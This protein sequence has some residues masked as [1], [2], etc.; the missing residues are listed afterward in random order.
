MK[1][2]LFV[3]IT[4]LLI[5]NLPLCDK[6]NETHN[7]RNSLDWVGIY[8]GIIPCADC[9]GINVQITLNSDETFKMSYQY[10]DKGGDVFHDAGI[11]RWNA[12]G[13]TIILD[14]KCVPRYYKV[15]ENILIQLDLEGKIISGDLANYYILKKQK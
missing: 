3:L 12:N 8:S 7:S 6:T 11:F 14:G 1:K 5:L 9:D 15:E 4:I 2:N 13:D 10:I